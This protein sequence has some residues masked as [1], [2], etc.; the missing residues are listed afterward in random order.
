MACR[1]PGA[2]DLA[3]FWDLLRHGVD[4]IEDAIPSR[5][6]SE[7]WARLRKVLRKPETNRVGGFLDRI[8]EFDA[9]FFGFSKHET[10]RMSPAHRL[11]FEVVWEALEDAGVPAGALAGSRT[12]VYTSAVSTPEYW[13]ALDKAGMCDMYAITGAALCSTAAGR[14]SF[15]LDLCGPHVAVDAACASSLFAVHMACASIRSGESSSA[16]V[17]AVNVQLGSSQTTAMARGRVISPNGT[18]RFGDHKPDGYVRSDGAVAVLLKPLSTALADGDRIYA[19]ILGGGVSSPGRTARTMVSPS[20]AAQ[21]QA[22]TTAHEQAGVTIADIDY[23]EAHGTGTARGDHTELTALGELARAGRDARDPCL[24]GSV[25]SNIGHTEAAAGLAGLIKTALAMSN[26]TIPPTLHVTEP[27]EILTHDLPV[28]L[29][30]QARPWPERGP[31]RVAGVSSFGVSGTNV[32]LVLASTQNSDRARVHTVPPRAYLLPVSAKTPGAVAQLASALADRLD[33]VGSVVELQDVVFSAGARRTHH[34]RRI[35]VVGRS[36]AELVD[37][38]RGYATGLSPASVVASVAAGPA[39]VREP[40]RTVFFCDGS[41]TRWPGLG[42]AMLVTNPVFLQRMQECD[43]AVADELGWSVLDRLADRPPDG[44]YDALPLVW[45]TQVGIAAVWQSWGIEPDLVLG[46]HTG[47]LA[48]ATIRGTLSLGEAA[49]LLAGGGRVP[50]AAPV[51]LSKYAEFAGDGRPTLFVEL[52]TGDELTSALTTAL[53]VRD[54]AH[55][56]ASLPPGMA[57]PHG[58]LT[59]L[60]EAYVRGAEVDWGAVNAGGQFV[61]LPGYP[62]QR[63]R[64]WWSDSLAGAAAR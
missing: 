40:L 9:D 54:T 28:S 50:Y 15:E 24:T 3:A 53:D 1:L 36:R 35:A 37:G 58:M 30:R 45:A 39:P 49:A 17:G 32:H 7:D 59:G 18:V 56:I 29:V 31:R 42:P 23:V 26:G 57:E 51:S 16:I 55:A 62:W 14:I 46:R 52:G 38:L 2:E 27:N 47:E 61:P 6:R 25:K 10:V 48:A 4:G 5:L 60:A 64:Y 43:K 12:A 20:A 22:I 11:Q 8:D 33:K 41:G 13:N 19:T 44:G 63:R 34:D 21:V